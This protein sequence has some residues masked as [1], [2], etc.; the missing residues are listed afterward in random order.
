MELIEA[1]KGRRSIRRYKPEKVPV[2]LVREVLD[3]ANYA[4]SAKRDEQWR[5]T[6]LTGDAK[7]KFLA[8]FDTEL[9][10]FIEEHGVREAGSSKGSCEVMVEAPVLVIVWNSG[11][12]GWT[13]EEHSVAAAIQNMLL[14]AYDLG[15][16]SLWIGDVYYAY[17]AIRSYFGKEWKLSG[18]VSLGYA[19]VEPKPFKRKTVDEVTEFLG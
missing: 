11:E 3:A 8:F 9:D 18:A 5:F 6:V 13:T 4:P 19:M 16:G 10:R 15:L 14:R 12:H 1:V 2:E 17:E 7:A